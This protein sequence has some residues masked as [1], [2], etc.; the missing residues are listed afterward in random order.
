MPTNRFPFFL[1]PTAAIPSLLLRFPH[2]RCY[3][4]AR[5]RPPS[6]PESSTACLELDAAILEFSSTP[7]APSSSPAERSPP[8]TSRPVIVSIE[9]PCPPITQRGSRRRRTWTEEIF[10]STFASL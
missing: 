9:S 10:S 3:P 8:P 4:R 1:L 5:L 2:Y 7:P 6:I